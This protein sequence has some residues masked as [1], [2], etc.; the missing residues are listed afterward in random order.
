MT[1]K[2]RKKKNWKTI[3]TVLTFVAMVATTYALRQQIYDTFQNLR[4]AN[5]WLILLVVPLAGGNNYFQAKVY[6]GLFRVFGEHF[7]LKPMFRLSLELNLVNNVLPS[8]GV[9]GFSY[10]NLRMK[11]ENVSVAKSTL[12]Q[13][14]R[15]SLLFI[16]F[17][18][19]LGLGLIMLAIGGQASDLMLLVAGS[20]ATLLVVSTAL[21][22]Y[23]IG[24]RSR[25][26]TFF[27]GLTRFI[28]RL[29]HVVRPKYPETINVESARNTFNE[30]HDH[31]KEMRGNLRQLQ[32]PLIASLFV[33]LTE[34]MAI[35][36]VFIAF[37]HFI[38]PGAVIIA[39]AVANFAG[40]VSVLPGGVGIYEAL[41]T[42]V[43]ATAGISAALSLPVTVAYRVLSMAVQ[44]PIGYILYQKSLHYSPP[45]EHGE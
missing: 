23:I 38:N 1:E 39:Y 3:A 18:V 43:F 11:A 26:D 12:V 33:S 15:F 2:I 14:M 28:N 19:L 22:I 40:L 44:I 9:S 45:Y 8:A 34:V 27:T 6:Q 17:Q 42:A 30:L 25:I 5:L 4:N 31:Y 7:R 21:S 41:M 13:I 29:I 24:S 16:S 10:L 20:L 36:S 32:K 37:G 35:Y